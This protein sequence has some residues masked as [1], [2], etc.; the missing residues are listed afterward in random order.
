MKIIDRYILK[1]YL[2]PFAYILG[3]FSLLYVILDLFDRFSD[4]V[5]AKA[6]AV[7]ILL[8]YGFFLFKVNGFVPFL[9]MVLPIAMLLATLY[10][11]TMFARHNELTA[12][13]ASGVSLRRLMLP[14]M[15]VGLCASIF[16]AVVQ[17]TMGPKATRWISDYTKQVLKHSSDSAFIVRDYLFHAGT[18]NRQ[19]LI[20]ELDQRTPTVLKGVKV[21]QE[22]ADSSLALEVTAERAEWMD[23]T[24]WFY[25][26]RRREYNEKSDPLGP[27]TEVLD[28]PVEMTD[29]DEQP[30]DFLNELMD[31]DF[32]STSDMIRSIQKRPDV[33]GRWLA[34]RLTDINSRVAMPWSC[35]VLILLG[36]PATMGGARR[37]A[38]RSVAFGVVALFTFYVL[39]QLGMI[40]GKREILSPWLAGWL[41]NLTF[42]GIGGWL[43]WRLR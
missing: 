21:T 7:D 29:Y 27:Q 9:V 13:C 41:P 19:W 26:V 12:M 1:Q 25:G 33:S 40:L 34:K 30:D 16:G 4:F 32:L 28:K 14:L 17:E 42:L 23:G 38:M 24:W 35:L 6:S 37:S 20:K 31:V 2:I 3:T 43:T 10:T 22:R 18:A 15:A 39:V 5:A 8:Y 11:L 36:L